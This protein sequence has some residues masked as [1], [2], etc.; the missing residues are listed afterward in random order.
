MV[1][2]GS[3]SRKTNVPGATGLGEKR[4]ASPVSTGTGSEANTRTVAR[5]AVRSAT[6][7]SIRAS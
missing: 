5:K 3:P 1:D 6:A 2:A 7:L 4:A